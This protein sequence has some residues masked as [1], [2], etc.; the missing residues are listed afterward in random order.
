MAISASSSDGNGAA[1]GSGTAVGAG[2][3]AVGTGVGVDEGE[4]VGVVVEVLAVDD[5]VV[6]TG[7]SAGI[8]VKEGDSVPSTV[9]VAIGVGVG[10]G[11]VGVDVQA[12]S[13][14]TKAGTARTCHPVRFK[15]SRRLAVAKSN[16][17]IPFL[18]S[19][20]DIKDKHSIL[21][22]RGLHSHL[23]FP[24]CS[25]GLVSLMRP[26]LLRVSTGSRCRVPLCKTPRELTLL[27]P[28]LPSR[29]SRLNSSGSVV[30]WRMF[31][32]SPN[33]F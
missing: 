8:E 16:S 2:G 24:V 6:G 9:V 14:N 12:I 30:T 13:A 18:H 1:V 23:G 31:M 5:I 17:P 27:L 21:E 11:S 4:I 3:M 19:Q 20:R 25:H 7:S 28:L 22:H 10:V 32:S 15:W 29:S 33:G 26:S